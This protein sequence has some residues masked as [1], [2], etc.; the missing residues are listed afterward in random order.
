[1]RFLEQQRGIVLAERRKSL[2]YFGHYR[3]FENIVV[4][5]LSAQSYDRGQ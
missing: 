1:M 4:H 5:L 3:V 2:N